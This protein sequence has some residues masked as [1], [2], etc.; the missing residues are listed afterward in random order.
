M[1]FIFCRGIVS[2]R[3]DTDLIKTKLTGDFPQIP[4]LP[5]ATDVQYR[6]CLL[7]CFQSTC[8]WRVYSPSHRPK[9]VGG[10]EFLPFNGEYLLACEWLIALCKPCSLSTTCYI[11]QLFRILAERR[12]YF[13][14]LLFSDCPFLHAHVVVQN[15]TGHAAPFLWWDN[16]RRGVDCLECTALPPSCST[17]WRNISITASV[18]DSVGVTGCCPQWDV[19]WPLVSRD[20][21]FA[22]D[23]S[24]TV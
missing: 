20:T 16:L 21:R 8:S 18:L 19:V 5:S 14:Y 24:E 1:G 2:R 6:R 7:S 17:P 11:S 23:L 10:C 15:P 9:R 12:V 4:K 3:A 13:C 22:S